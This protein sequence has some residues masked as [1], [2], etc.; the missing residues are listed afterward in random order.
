MSISSHRWALSVLPLALAAAVA[1][2]ACGKKEAAPAPAADKAAAKTPT[3]PAAKEAAKPAADKAA[4]PKAKA[5]AAALPA[6]AGPPASDFVISAEDAK[7]LHGKDG[8]VFVFAGSGKNFAAGHIA[9]SVHAFAHDMQYLDDVQKCDGLPMCAD[10]A[11]SYIGGLGIDNKTQVIAYDDGKGV[12][13]SG[14]WFFLQVFGHTNV[15]ILTGGMPDWKAKGFPVETGAAKAP[16]A[17]TFN[18]KVNKTMIATRADAQ[19]A[20]KSDDAMLLDARHTLPEYA[21]QDLKESM[22]NAADHVT[23]KRGGHLPTALFSP[24]TKY[25]GN[26]GGVAGK[27]VFRSAKK[28]RKQLKKLVKKGY[29]KDKT[30]ITY[31]HVGLGRSTFQYLGLRLAG[32]DKAKVYVGSWADWGSTDLPIE[33]E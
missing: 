22:K 30:L 11:A 15:K 27:P 21:G 31:C 25:A 29:S 32:H 6:K 1:L 4:K 23:V 13:E 5:A 2:T 33:T 9:G 24:W 8:V 16:A 10:N 17:K 20:T 26:K 7:A 18:V 3:E 14:V 28:L 19:A 12:N